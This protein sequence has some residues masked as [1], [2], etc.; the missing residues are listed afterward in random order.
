MEH[1]ELQDYPE[2]GARQSSGERVRSDRLQSEHVASSLHQRVLSVAM[3]RST[4]DL[5]S[6]TGAIQEES[7]QPT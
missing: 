3:V 6:S 7:T 1:I 4:L 2:L 5:I